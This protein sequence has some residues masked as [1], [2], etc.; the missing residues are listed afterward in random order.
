MTMHSSHPRVERARPAYSTLPHPTTTNTSSFAPASCMCA[1][2]NST[3]ST[4]VGDRTCEPC[5]HLHGIPIHVFS[6]TTITE[7]RSPSRSTLGLD[8]RSI[9]C[10]L[11]SGEM[12]LSPNRC[13][14]GAGWWREYYSSSLVHLRLSGVPA[15]SGSECAE[16]ALPKYPPDPAWNKSSQE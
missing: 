2:A 12:A 4:D 13:G 10:A 5:K 15:K 7:D 11:R 9:R 14:V 1:P 3:A 16:S 8:V 6:T